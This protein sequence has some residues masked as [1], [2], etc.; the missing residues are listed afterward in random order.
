[1]GYIVGL[2]KLSLS[3]SFCKEIKFKNYSQWIQE[4]DCCLGLGLNEELGRHG[5][6][7]DR[8]CVSYV[9]MNLRV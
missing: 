4:H 8:Q 2:N 3:K 6:K 5:G 9:G 1:M 7:N